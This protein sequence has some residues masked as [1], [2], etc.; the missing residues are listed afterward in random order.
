MSYFMGVD[1]GGTSTSAIIGDEEFNVLAEYSGG[2]SNYQSAGIEKVK[3]NLQLLFESFKTRHNLPMN[4]IKSI[5]IGCAG[6]N[7]DFDRLIYEDMIR[8]L[9]Y[10]GKLLVYNDAVTALAGANGIMEGAVLIS[11]TGSIAY[12]INKK[13]EHIRIGGW[14]H[15]I[16]D[17]G[18]GYAI[19][20]DALQ[21]VVQSFDGRIPPTKLWNIISEKLNIY[22]IDQLMS[23]IYD[24]NTKKQHIAGIAPYVI[25]IAD[26]DDAALDIVRKAVYDLKK[27]VDA[28][29]NR[30]SLDCYDL[31]MSGSILLKTSRIRDELSNEIK[32]INP[33][34]NI[35]LP[36]NKPDF[37]ALILA[38]NN[39]NIL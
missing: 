9:G 14:G 32:L 5:C 17:E 35:H 21:K 34:I 30:L 1:G 4:D 31:A 24:P 13:G 25:D 38:K 18:S 22:S 28:L 8:S 29:N 39:W 33:K 19:G 12:G 37:G 6:V 27:M 15:I 7:N 11:G 3:E 10:N 23:Y 16:G 2:A 20:R 26:E 36:Y